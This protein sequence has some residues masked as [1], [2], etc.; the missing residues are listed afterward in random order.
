M[1]GGLLTSAVNSIVNMQNTIN[2]TNLTTV[3][4]FIVRMEYMN[5]AV[6]N[7]CLLLV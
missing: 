3:N 6:L 1:L 4:T 2:A 7:A 5:L